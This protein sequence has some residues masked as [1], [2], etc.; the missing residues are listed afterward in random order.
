[1]TDLEN[2]YLCM[3]VADRSFLFL[4]EVHSFKFNIEVFDVVG[5]D[6]YRE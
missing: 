6:F 3:Y 2:P 5:V 1:M 4:I